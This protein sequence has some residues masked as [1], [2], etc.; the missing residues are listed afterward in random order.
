[1]GGF[2][3]ISRQERKDMLASVGLPPDPDRLF[4]IIPAELRL[5]FQPE[6]QELSDPLTEMEIRKKVGDLASQNLAAADM[7]CFLGA[8]AYDHYL[9]A[10]I[11]HLV[12][13]Q[14]FLTAYTPYQPE[15]SQGTLQAI[16]EFQSLICRLT[17]LDIAN[18][19]MYDGA[20]A[21]AEALL[22]ACRSTGRRKVLVASTVHPH[23]IEVIR[24]YLR[25]AGMSMEVLPAGPDGTWS[26]ALAGQA[27]DQE[28]A[29]VLVQSPNFFGLIENQARIAGLA[30]QAGAL[31]VASC[32]PLSLALL[33]PPGT[34][35]MDIAVGDIQPLGNPLSFGGP[36]A[37][38]LAARADLLR[39][40]P[41]RI[42]GETTD[43]DGRRAFVLTIQA[44]EQHIR[45][46]KATSNICTNQALCALSATIYLS[47]M[48]QSGLADAARQCAL[49]AAKLRQ[50]LLESGNFSAAFNQPFFRE[51]VVRLCPDRWPK[52]MQMKDLNDYL[53]LH[54]VIGG[55]DLGREDPGA[56]GSG[57]WLLAVTEKRS[58]DDLD[59]LISLIKSYRQARG[60]TA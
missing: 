27:P 11:R 54:G 15:I 3:P 45:R 7:I 20:S 37:G 42:A 12:L 26:D 40:M 52:T 19:S 34:S 59:R 6:C 2:V 14:E 51:F 53:A 58:Q 48:G 32:D 47:L 25:A 16:F 49:N 24:T 38:Y 18:S 21:A 28:T 55:Y 5:Q 35:G 13:R 10:A 50:M 56:P 31:A 36:Y 43:Q 41:G 4:D 57:C 44:R 8:G 23:T 29:A 17:G 60:F 33:V 1:M 39:R 9:P 30:H 22:M 46:E